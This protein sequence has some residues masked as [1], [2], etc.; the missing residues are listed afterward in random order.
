MK[1]QV[2]FSQLDQCVSRMGATQLEFDI[3]SIVFNEVDID[4]ALG[5]T[6]VDI[7]LDEL[8]SSN[9]LLSYHGRQVLLYIPDHGNNVLNTVENPEKGRKFHLA[10]CATLEQ[11][12]HNN[13]FERYVATNRMDGLFEI[14]G[15]EYYDGETQRHMVPLNVCK[16]CLKMLSYKGYGN[17]SRSES[18]YIFQEFNLEDFFEQYSTMFRTLPKLKNEVYDTGYTND[19]EEI[20]EQCRRKANYVCE[21]CHTDFSHDKHLLHVHH[22]DGIKSNNSMSNLKVLC[23]DCHR[24]EPMHTHLYISN[25]D[26]SRIYEL[27]RAQ[28]KMVGNSW[29]D[30]FKVADTALYGVLY[31]L[32]S[33]GHPVPQIAYPVQ[34]QGDTI[35]LEIAYP[36]QKIAY[37]T[38][39]KRKVPEW[40]IWTIA[41]VLKHHQ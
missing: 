9:G 36:Q 2:D 29:D 30:V 27:R 24:K 31:H 14:S 7:Q 38:D 6:G 20:S 13:R 41:Q 5:T 25:K 19:W 16:N 23:A 4:E 21:S 1:L 33:D 40:K 10:D 28:G 34:V 15:T 37:V 22:I 18:N 35:L 8:E 32:K 12:R 3:G 17:R 11:M 39:D 26:M